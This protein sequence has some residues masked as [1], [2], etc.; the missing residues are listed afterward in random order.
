[1]IFFFFQAEDGIRYFHVTGVQT[2]ALPIYDQE[3]GDRERRQESRLWHASRLAARSKI[4]CGNCPERSGSGLEQ[5]P[6]TGGPPV[7]QRLRDRKSVVQAKRLY[8]VSGL[9]S[10]V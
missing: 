9:G 10:D 8:M 4:V 1:F 3:G 5:R 2:C 7:Q 6:F